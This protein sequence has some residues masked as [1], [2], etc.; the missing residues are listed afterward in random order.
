M[1]KKYAS[2]VQHNKIKNIDYIYK[3]VKNIFIGL[4]FLLQTSG[5][6]YNKNNTNT[7]TYQTK[8]VNTPIFYSLP[9][10]SVNIL[11]QMLIKLKIISFLNNNED[12]P[13]YQPYYHAIH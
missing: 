5:F 2:C 11:Y 12:T 13:L 3:N 6:S 1:T 10:I 9:K 7:N 4:L 8:I